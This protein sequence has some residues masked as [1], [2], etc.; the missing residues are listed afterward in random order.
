[1]KGLSQWFYGSINNLSSIEMAFFLIDVIC[2][3]NTFILDANMTTL[4]QLHPSFGKIASQTILD[5]NSWH[6]YSS[7]YFKPHRVYFRC[8]ILPSLPSPNQS[9]CPRKEE[10]Q[11]REQHWIGGGEGERSIVDLWK[12]QQCGM[13]VKSANIYVQD[14]I[15]AFSGNLCNCIVC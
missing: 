13:C 10:A 12:F 7:A 15:F 14:C 8:Y 5:I 3:A 4:M 2:C 11:A 1:M 6:F 9:C